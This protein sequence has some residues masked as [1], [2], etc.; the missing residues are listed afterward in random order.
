MFRSQFVGQVLQGGG[1][2]GTGVAQQNEAGVF[3]HPFPRRGQFALL[4]F[5][6]GPNPF[7]IFGLDPLPAALAWIACT[8]VCHQR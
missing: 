2:A 7:A 8:M 4:E 1:F 6:A 3:V 5:V